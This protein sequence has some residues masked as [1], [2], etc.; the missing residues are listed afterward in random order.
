MWRLDAGSLVICLLGVLY[1]LYKEGTCIYLYI[2]LWTLRINL[3][4]LPMMRQNLLF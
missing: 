2:N 1:K 4:L 3:I